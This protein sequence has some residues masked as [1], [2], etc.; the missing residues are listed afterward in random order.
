[1]SKAERRRVEHH[2]VTRKSTLLERVRL[3]VF[4]WTLPV[5]APVGTVVVISEPDTT[6]NA[7]GMP[8]KVT[9]VAPVRFVLRRLTFVP[10]VPKAGSVS[11]KGPSPT[12]RLKTVPTS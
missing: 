5:V 4:T 11:T 1:M 7:V 6:V 10:T 8:L 2:F 9:L 3:G 12:A